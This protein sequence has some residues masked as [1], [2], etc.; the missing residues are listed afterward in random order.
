M[1]KLRA[2]LITGSP[3]WGGERA[4]LVVDR[5]EAVCPH[6]NGRE[7]QPGKRLHRSQLPSLFRRRI[8]NPGTALIS[9][10]VEI[11]WSCLITLMRAGDR[12]P[13]D[14]PISRSC[15]TAVPAVQPRG[16][17]PCQARSRAQTS[18]KPGP[19]G[20]QCHTGRRQPDIGTVPPFILLCKLLAGPY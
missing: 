17:Q 1:V 13:V 14:T 2:K 3:T 6:S 9:L 10:F 11:L 20:G 4:G 8:M 16:I 15:H 5:A 12:P 18:T 19:A 7:W